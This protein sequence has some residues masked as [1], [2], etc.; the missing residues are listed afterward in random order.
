M[1]VV[2]LALLANEPALTTPASLQAAALAD[3]A[4][5]S[6]DDRLYTRYLSL[7]PL[8]ITKRAELEVALAFWLAS[9][10]NRRANPPLVWVA[11]GQLWRLALDAYDFS[12]EAWEALGN[13]DPYFKYTVQD[14]AT[15][16]RGWLDPA[17][18]KT[19]YEMTNSYSPVVRAD[20]FLAKTSL[21]VGGRNPFLTGF[22]S[23]FARLPDTEAKLFQG[24]GLD[25]KLVAKESLDRGDGVQDSIVALHNRE[26]QRRPTL[27][28]FLWRSL[29]VDED[30]SV[31]GS[32]SITERFKGTIKRA[33]SEHI[34]T[35]KNG[36]HRYYLANADG[37]QV[38]EVPSKIAQHRGNAND[39]TVFTPLSCIECHTSSSGIIPFRGVVK[40]VAL[41]ERTGLA[42]ITQGDYDPKERKEIV[43]SLNDYY[44][45]SLK[46]DVNSDQLAYEAA[47]KSATGKTTLQAQT[48][49]LSVVHGYLYGR[50]GLSEFAAET[51]N[52]PA[53]AIDYV[54]R[55]GAGTLQVL[56]AGKTISREA[57]EVLYGK[58]MTARIYS[59]ESELRFA[60]PVVQRPA[61][62][63]PPSALR[64]EELPAGAVRE[65]R[66][67]SDPA[68]DVRYRIGNQQFLR[69]G[70][71]LFRANYPNWERVK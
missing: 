36:M 50:V 21:E 66:L 3:L 40:D 69:R 56:R 46:A 62:V 38:A 63:S 39:S 18:V 28:G 70:E 27:F 45:D 44:A 52:T 29:D 16:T 61:K 26:L 6:P 42:V 64:I 53:G 20:F 14:G 48:A 9:L 32:K 71:V 12:A 31:D 43:R 33:G 58:A 24:L 49:Y 19:L 23:K 47:V 51:G 10:N 7:F 2:V 68:G 1:L 5:L 60:I 54:V 34:F 65:D 55:S 67:P 25:E 37:K 41:N 13:A 22:Y 30:F 11:N 17:V 15:V 8:P 35:G 59:W 57:F 4:T